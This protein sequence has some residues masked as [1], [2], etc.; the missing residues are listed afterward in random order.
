MLRTI[1]SGRVTDRGQSQGRVHRLE[2]RFSQLSLRRRSSLRKASFNPRLIRRVST[3]VRL[4]SS[5]RLEQDDRELLDLVNGYLC[6]LD[7]PVQ[8][9]KKVLKKFRK[10]LVQT[11]DRAAPDRKGSFSS[12]TPAERSNSHVAEADH[13]RASMNLHKQCLHGYEDRGA[14]EADILA[15]VPI[16][17]RSE[18]QLFLYGQHLQKCGLFRSLFISTGPGKAQVVRNLAFKFVRE[19]YA[20]G[21]YVS[22]APRGAVY[23]VRRGGCRVLVNGKLEIV[24]KPGSCVESGVLKSGYVTVYREGEK[25]VVYRAKCVSVCAAA[26]RPSDPY[27]YGCEL[28]VLS[29]D[30]FDAMVSDDSDDARLCSKDKGKESELQ[31]AQQQIRRSIESLRADVAKQIKEKEAAE[32][33]LEVKTRIEMESESR[34]AASKELEEACFDGSVP[35]IEEALLSGADIEYRGSNLAQRPIHICTKAGDINA[36][37]H[38]IKRGCKVSTQDQRGKTPLHICAEKFQIQQHAGEIAFFL[39]QRGADMASKDIHGNTPIHIAAARGDLAL[40]KIFRDFNSSVAGR[41]L[42]ITEFL[43]NHGQST[44]GVCK[45]Q[46]SRRTLKP[47][48]NLAGGGR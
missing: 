13:V 5:N 27:V 18:C 32:E 29:K 37:K 48:T 44:V 25:R 42:E 7:Y 1:S 39:L 23:V 40:L 14:L 19:Q 47:K 8:L 22:M 33:Q 12:K 46:V 34:M 17:T 3:L 2:R 30:D 11:G 43:N 6:D 15:A 21:K 26:P 10:H 41:N 28:G 35:R 38:L 36:V 20:P 31:L 9:R 4:D 24:V 16:N 45:K